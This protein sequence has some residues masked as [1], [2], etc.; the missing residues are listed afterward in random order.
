[1]ILENCPKC[2]QRIPVGCKACPCGHAYFFTRSLSRRADLQKGTQKVLI[3]EKP[4]GQMVKTRTSQDGEND[5]EGNKKDSVIIVMTEAKDEE[6]EES[7]M[8]EEDI[9]GEEVIDEDENEDP[10]ANSPA[11]NHE[12]ISI[13]LEELNKKNQRVAWKPAD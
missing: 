11:A 5:E 7:L 13:I 6:D 9:M 3:S 2:D 10:Y 8:D 1:M 12:L 4:R